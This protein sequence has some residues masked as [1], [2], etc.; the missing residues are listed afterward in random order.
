MGTA[1]L[2]EQCLPSSAL[3][4]HVRVR[5]QGQVVGHV[6]A[7][8]WDYEGGTFCWLSQL[9]VSSEFRRRGFATGL[10]KYL[11]GEVGPVQ[12]Y[13]I[14][15]CHPAAISAA[16]RAF[17]RSLKEVNLE[18]IKEQAGDI[19]ANAPIKYVKHAMLRGSLFEQ[20]VEDGTV[21]SA[22]TN[23]WV[24]HDGPLEALKEIRNQGKAWP[25][26][27]LLEGHEFLLIMKSSS[28]EARQAGHKTS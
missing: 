21:S 6:F 1:T 17:G 22:Y 3:N 9:V 18:L 4:I 8:R 24:D 12:G 23:F 10:L 27:E 26:G 7:S 19:L 5:S 2:E 14:L 28:N 15:S 13:G 20:D 25:F 11:R 16:V